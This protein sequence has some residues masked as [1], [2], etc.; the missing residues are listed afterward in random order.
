M[1]K[2]VHALIG[3]DSFFQLQKLGEILAQMPADVVRIDVDG[4]RAE[5]AD[6]FDELRSFAMFGSGKLVVMRNADAFITKFREQLED[7]LQ[8]PSDSA[9]LVMR[10]NSL[11]ANQKVYKLIQK[12]GAIEKCEPPKEYQLPAWIIA[13]G[14]DVHKITVAMDAAK[15]LADRIGA[16]L[17]RLDN[18]LAKLA[19]ASD[20]GKIAVQD[21][22]QSVAFQREQE[23]WD[24]TNELAQGKPAEALKRWRQLVAIDPATEF[25]AVTWLTMWLEEVG[26]ILSGGN[27]SKLNWKY[28]DRLPQVIKTAKSF[29]K[30]R[31]IHAVDLLADLD[32]RSKSGL[33][34]ASENVERFIVSF[35]S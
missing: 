20:S 18:E 34:D 14:K 32:R 8:Q 1:P 25:R 24:M 33:G 12:V 13:R 35:A 9:T 15:L 28:R 31:Y 26:N 11:P 23:M 22:S 27:T 5:L 29:G 6:V 19:L 16:D 17:G 21:I 3:D 4:E 7:Y 2:P 30:D 10:I